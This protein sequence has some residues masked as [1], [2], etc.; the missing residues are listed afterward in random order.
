MSRFAR[1]KPLSRK[2]F[3]LAL[4]RI[5]K[6]AQQAGRSLREQLLMSLGE[7][8][9]AQH[10]GP[11]V[12]ALPFQDLPVAF[13]RELIH[14]G[15][16]RSKRTPGQQIKKVLRPWVLDENPKHLQNW[17][18]QIYGEFAQ[19][20]LSEVMREV[21]LF[22]MRKDEKLI[23]RIHAAILRGEV[24]PLEQITRCVALIHGIRY[25]GTGQAARV[26]SQNK[27]SIG[28]AYLH[29]FE[30]DQKP[31]TPAAIRVDLARDLCLRNQRAKRPKFS[32]IW[33]LLRSGATN[34]EDEAG[35]RSRY[36]VMRIRYIRKVM[37]ALKWPLR[38]SPRGPVTVQSVKTTLD[39]A[40]RDYVDDSKT[41]P[42]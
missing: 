21:L 37:K 31:P 27:K 23:Q 25:E 34:D 11:D 17:Y 35:P 1:K 36:E 6:E 8:G 32:D 12:T 30:I 40:G 7:Y 29:L 26:A 38:A 2:A 5:E 3:E 33:Y 22:A 14:F 4:N 20:A 10:S 42:E 39:R 19:G 28:L 18:G 16:G 41:V 13:F 24:K 15:A 9:K